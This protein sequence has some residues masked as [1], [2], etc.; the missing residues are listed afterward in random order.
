MHVAPLGRLTS[1]RPKSRRDRPTV[2]IEVTVDKRL[3]TSRQ[4]VSAKRHFRARTP[5]V[6]RPRCDRVARPCPRPACKSAPSSRPP[7]KVR[8]PWPIPTLVTLQRPAVVYVAVTTVKQEGKMLDRT[9]RPLASAP[10]SSTPNTASSST[11]SASQAQR[12]LRPRTIWARWA[13][14]S[15]CAPCS[16]SLKSLQG[17]GLQRHPHQPQPAGA[18]AAGPLRPHGLPRDGRGV[19]LLGKSAS[20]RNDY[21]HL[22][23]DWHEKDCRANLRRDRESSQHHPLEHRQR[24]ARAGNG[25][26]GRSSPAIV[27]IKKT[28]RPTGHDPSTG[29]DGFQ[30]SS[31]SSAITTNRLTTPRA[32]QQSEPADVWQRNRLLHQFA[33]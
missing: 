3:G 12:R 15:T 21:H 28:P 24:S 32:G 9:K 31:M 27:A 20:G 13:R 14:Q 26:L 19:R 7:L 30:T 11:A 10:S 2:K 17:N 29:F 8:P 16:A 4:R 6:T 22:F 5:K 25:W 33:R 18:G 1:P 23:D